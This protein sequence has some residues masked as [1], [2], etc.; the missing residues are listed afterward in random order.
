MVSYNIAMY[1]LR[2]FQKLQNLENLTPSILNGVYSFSIKMVYILF[3]AGV[4]VT[5]I[6]YD[7][8]SNDVLYWFTFYT[9]VLFARLSSVYIYKYRQDIYSLNHW[10]MIYLFFVFTIAIVVSSLSIL[11][12][13]HVA[14]E[15]QF[16]IIIVTLSLSSGASSLFPTNYR[17]GIVYIAIIMIPLIIMISIMN[18][19]IHYA[20]IVLLLLYN[21]GLIGM[22]Y[23]NYQHEIE[24]SVLQSEQKSL[25]H[26][27]K[28]VP[29][30][31][32]IY[33]NTFKIIECNEHFLKLF[34]N[35]R[36][37]I[38]GLNL[39][40]M[41]DS[42]DTESLKKAL[43]TGASVYKGAYTSIKGIDFWI[44]AKIFPYKNKLNDTVGHMVLIEDKSKEFRI[45]KELQYIADH[46]PLTGLLNRRGLRNKMEKLVINKKHD[47]YY[48]LL[49]YLD[50]NKFKGINDSLGHTVGDAVL[51]NVSQRLKHVLSD[52]CE[53]SRL[54]GDEFLIIVP[55]CSTRKE[56]VTREAEQYAQ[57]IQGIFDDSFIIEEL[58]LHIKASMGIIIIEPKYSNIEE[59]IRHADITMYHAKTASTHISYYNEKLD[60]KQKKLFALQHDL[61]YAVDRKQFGL[62][63]QPIV[64]ISD[65]KRYAAEALIRWYHPKKGLLGPNDFIPLA[66]EAG[67]LSKITWWVLNEVCQHISRWKKEGLWNLHHISINVNAQQLI[68]NNFADTFLSTLKNY[69]LDNEDIMVEITERSLI[70]NFDSTQNVINILR[71]NGIRCAIDD[72][73]IG[74]SSLSYLKKLSF[75]TLK[76]DKEFVKDIEFNKKEL[77]LVSSI[78]TIGKEFGYNI[79][80]EG[81]EDEK[82]RRL[83][84][85]LDKDL[86][87][88][89]YL[90]SKPLNAEDFRE[91]FLG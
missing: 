12:M 43:I 88:Q 36:N 53:I 13:S 61:A 26:L 10:Y 44:E 20:L 28:E 79:V 3:G 18:T 49:F 32:F 56:H 7:Q 89:G 47:T 37:N 6:L 85:D 70:D 60:I 29:L 76:I 59:I 4:T 87:Y 24:F 90:Y 64:D 11:F 67:L 75:N 48:S 72:F 63:F 27:F 73:G 30:G 68:E 17:L 83:L 40:S 38:I 14:L 41:P 35:E 8:V 91:K 25:T 9:M 77:L 58:H 81:I 46:D 15:Y 65:N 52:S 78:L 86:K 22:I 23:R 54:G 2:L 66:I 45:Q 39:K 50:L 74:Y 21:L 62:F 19:S 5:Y 16:V 57:S 1:L 31:I 80:I 33:D 55:Y 51:L 82:Q 34:D 69:G 84:Y 71:N 42:G